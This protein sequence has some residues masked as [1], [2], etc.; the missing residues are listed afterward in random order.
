MTKLIW[1]M[2]FLLTGFFA[3]VGTVVAEAD[4][5]AQK[6][7]GWGSKKA[8]GQSTPVGKKAK[9]AKEV[10]GCPMDPEVRSDKAGK[11]PKC[12]MDLEKMKKASPK[13][14]AGTSKKVYACA[15][16]HITSDKPGKCPECGMD[17]VEKEKG[18]EKKM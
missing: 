10:W 5:Y 15:M 2:A 3:A 12:G 18:P 16:C 17:M 7:P 4:G 1:V 11:C 6:T 14:A 8:K 9:T 13:P